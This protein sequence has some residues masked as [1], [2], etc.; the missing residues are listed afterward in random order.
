MANASEIPKP[1]DVDHLVQIL[2][3]DRVAAQRL[4][5]IFL[6]M[7]PDKLDLINAALEREDWVALRRVV[8]DLRGCCALFSAKVCIIL[9]SKLEDALP[10]H[11]DTDLFKN[12]T[13]F[14]EALADL[15]EEL[16]LF[17]G[18]PSTVR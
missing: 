14:K 2:A 4:A 10:D 8:R 5:Q 1:C 3:G 6:N 15:A 9:A 11:I 7:Y 18:A 17:L 12:C 16:R 13:R